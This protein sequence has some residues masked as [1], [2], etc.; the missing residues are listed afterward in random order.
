MMP[1]DMGTACNANYAWRIPVQLLGVGRGG[2]GGRGRG[3]AEGSLSNGNGE[4]KKGG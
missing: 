1:I 3:R 2:G 4:D